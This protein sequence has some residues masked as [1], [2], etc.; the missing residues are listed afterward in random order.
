MG[1]MWYSGKE[2]VM[3]VGT[4]LPEKGDPC[5]AR[6]GV[7]QRDLRA[8]FSVPTS[9]SGRLGSVTALN[10]LEQRKSTTPIPVQAA[11]EVETARLWAGGF[12]LESLK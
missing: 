11:D 9:R 7:P 1:R 5:R 6:A 3:E 12:R 2:A 10:G 4:M 8:W